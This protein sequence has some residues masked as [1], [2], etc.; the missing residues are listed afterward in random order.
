MYRKEK[1]N[2]KLFS[3]I[4][5]ALV[6]MAMA[7]GVGVAVSGN[8]SK[9]VR[10]EDVTDNLTA[11]DLAATTTT[12]T[13][14]SNVSKTSD[15][16]YAGNSA[17]DGSG[18]I[19][20]RSKNS[21]S[22]IVS[23]TSGGKVKSVTITVGSGSNTIDVY[24]SNSA[25]SSAADLYVS[26]SAGTLIGSVAATGTVSF[27]DDYEFVGIRSR[28]GAIYVTSVEITWTSGDTP[29]DPL[30]S[31]V[32][33]GS[34]TKTS[35]Y[36]GES[37]SSAG[38]TATGHYESGAS[39]DVTAK[40]TWSFNPASPAVSVTSVVATATIGEVSGSSSAQSV[41]V[42][43]TNPIQVLYTKASGAEVDVYGYYVGFLDG[44][45]P[46]IMDGE[47]GIVIYNKSAD[48]SSYTEGETILHV[49]GSISIYKGL[50][51]VGSATITVASGTYDVPSTPVVYATAGGETAEYAS[52][53]TTVTGTAVVSSGSFDSAAGTAD[54]TMT[55]T[56]GSKTV[57]VFYKKAAQTADADA[58]A[59]MKQAVADST[60]I[61]IKGFTG[62]YNGFQVQM[63]GYIPPAEDYTAEEFSQDL[64]DQTDAVCKD[65]DDVTNNHDAIEAIWSNLASNDKYPSLP[66]AQKTILAEAARD[67]SG[68]VVEQAMARYDYLTGKYNLSNFINGR[69]PV[70][71]A[72]PSTI[73]SDNNINSSMSIIVVAV[74]A[75]TSLSAIG[76]LLVIKRRKSI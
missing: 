7:V 65:Y 28:S 68:T 35:Y 52:R 3:K 18:N 30:E 41:T 29:T 1:E 53:L 63:N 39:E 66:A 12:Y 50:Y 71:F 62:W 27:S 20:M 42:T 45:G 44:T 21:N 76:V 67:E 72:A 57:Q 24:G 75:I 22:G 73:S 43:K 38:L 60:E 55:F 70:V 10:A 23:T 56:V 15:A 58:F 37:W 64:L 33:S 25:Y 47:Y 40:V 13:D 26:S 61:T 4:A 16:L 59:A 14:F 48:V 2:M 74:I 49:T 8:N 51:E 19:Q 69:T 31:I 46:V 9:E 11:S 6:G 34:M 5:T 54:I 32:V 17:K 36:V